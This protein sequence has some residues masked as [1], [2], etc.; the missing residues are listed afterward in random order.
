MLL[1]HGSNVEVSEPKIVV[2]NRSLDFGAG[3]YT[4]ADERQAEK[5][6]KLQTLRRKNGRPVVSVYTFDENKISD[7]RVL[8]FKSA[9]SKWLKYVS[10]NRKGIYLGE[11]YDVVVGPI[12]NDSTM[13]VINSYVSGRIDEETALILLKPQ[14]LSTQYVFLTD[15]G[16]SRLDFLEVKLIE[17]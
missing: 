9:D 6:S 15:T 10:D 5:W 13:T 1:F 2:S 7:L 12:A 4:S 3:F 17:E 14:K 16:L 8:R 11:K